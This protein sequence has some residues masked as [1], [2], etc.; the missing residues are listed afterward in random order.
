VLR[1]DG[2]AGILGLD[3]A[4]VQA[5]P[6][7]QVM[8]E[9]GNILLGGGGSDTIIG[10]GGDDIIDG[11]AWL[12]VRIGI[13]NANGVEIGT[14]PRMQG[15]VTMYDTSSPLH[16]K[17]LDSL[18]FSRQLNPGQLSI[19]REILDGEEAGD[20]DIAV[21]RGARSEYTVTQNANGTWTVAH[22]AAALNGGAVSDGTDTLR[23]VE[24]LQFADVVQIID[25]AVSN[26]LSTGQLGITES[27][28]GTPARVGETFTVT[29]GTVADT[30]GLPPL[31]QFTFVWQVEETPGAG[32][33]VPIEDPIADDLL[34]TGPSFTPTPAYE[35]E[36][37][38]IRVV[39]SFIDAHGIPEVVMSAPSVPLSAAVS[40]VAT[41]GDDVLFGTVG[42]DVIDA[43][44]GDDEVFGLGGNDT[45]IGGPG[46]DIL[47][48]GEGNDTA[49][50]NG[51]IAD[52]T[53]EV[54]DEGILEVVD[55]AA[56]EEDAVISIENFQFTDGTLTLAQVNAIIA[57]GGAGGAATGGAD[58][59]TG[60]PG[61]DVID[62][63]G[64]P[65]TING[66]DGADDL[67]GG[68]G[69][70]TINGGAGGDTINGDG[71][72]DTLAGDAGADT[73]NG[74]AGA[75]TISGGAGND[76]L[77]GDA[78]ADTINGNAGN[79]EI[80]G[81]DGADILFGD[82]GNDT[83]L[84]GNGADEITGGAGSDTL[85][86]GAG[87]DMFVFGNNF[88]ADTITDFD[89]VGGGQDLIDLTAFNLAFNQ[90]TIAQQGAD[91]VITSGVAGFGSITLEN[92]TAANIQADD[93]NL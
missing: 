66:G 64:G 38:R 14:A 21:F 83:I 26:S 71:G 31:S 18:I 70:D 20:V 43:L 63:L 40:P 88:G 53:F 33:W 68:A 84:G 6:S 56:G 67:S 54:T 49:V 87:V 77:F 37:L 58:V 90:L 80:D 76:E 9:H 73:I 91:T 65:D 42:D 92:T 60:T 2:L 13:L 75:D 35:L 74:G 23:N 7:T 25:P 61:P 78:G 93:F 1:I 81:G 17:T 44:A 29:L 48:G 41:I 34:I 57:A 28:P 45:L 19:V 24:V 55:D 15:E 79:D 5:L 3:E 89:D 36:G 86:G 12:N 85:T 27:E 4:A 22:T 11:D 50:F 46:N 72:A 69:A 82:G 39:G 16:G 10:N 59:I 52:F 32:D 51:A 62:G 8:F 47:D 30:D